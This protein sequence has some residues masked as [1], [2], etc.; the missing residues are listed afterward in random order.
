[1]R[2]VYFTLAVLLYLVAL[3]FLLYLRMKPK[4]H[5]SIPARFF[6]KDNPPFKVNGAWFHACSFGEVRSL[7]PFIE[8][9]A[10][11]DVCISAITQTGFKEAKK[12][13]FAHVR[14]LPF[15][16]FLPFWVNKHK[17]LVVMEAELWPLLFC[18]AKAKGIKTVLLNA[19]ISDHSYR[20][21]TKFRWF[22]RWIF[23][24]IDL[25]LAQSEEDK[26]RLMHLGAKQVEVC[27]NVKQFQHY[28][29]T[30]VY[31][32]DPTKRLIILASTHENEEELILGS[33]RLHPNDQVIVVP[34]HPERFEKVG[35]WLHAYATRHHHSYARFSEEHLLKADMILCD[36]M[37]ELI[38][39]YAIADIVILGGSFVD[40][41][42]GHN[43]LEPAFFGVKL[44][45][46]TFIFNQKV[47]FAS[48]ENSITCNSDTLAHVFE[49]IEN[50]PACSISHGGDIVP[51]LDKIL[52]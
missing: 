5:D 12:Y 32:K 30:N 24:S 11:D 2:F 7:A 50:Y 38:N 35:K 43:P 41:I 8:K 14:Y 25:V 21:Y 20:S 34:R 40:G 23:Q 36:T 44:I 46:G 19:R 3:P 4:Y 51:L 10:G 9:L 6:L 47:L 31:A 28:D 42:G 13:S 26:S 52:G 39:L 49:T 18:V 33:L 17:V 48:V 45:S 22:Y 27:G 15:E 37:G 16:I 1:L 29:V